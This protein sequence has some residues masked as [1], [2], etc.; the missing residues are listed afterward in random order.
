MRYPEFIK[1]GDTIGF[2]APSFG[3]ASEPYRSAFESSIGA[4]ESMGFNT[5]LGPNC[6]EGSGIGISS[7]PESCGAELTAMYCGDLGECSAIMACGGGELMCETLEHVDLE[8]IAAARPKWYSGFSDNTNFIFPLVTMCDTAAVY[9]PNAP[10][11]GMEPWHKNLS[12]MMDILTGKKLTV[13]SYRRWESHSLKSEENPLEPYN[14][15]EK[16][17]LILKNTASDGTIDMSGRLLGGCMD[18]LAMLCGTGFDHVGKFQERYARDGIIWFLEACDLNVFSMR[19]V[20]WQ[21][22]QAGWFETAKGFII[23]R[24]YH[25]DEPMMGLDRI[26]AVMGIAG[27]HNVPV[28]L[29]ADVG[30][31]PPMMPLVAGS[32]AH[33]RAGGNRMRVSM[34]LVD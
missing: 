5:L 31:L 26:E 24:P 10:A 12:Y 7:S 1:K 2:A 34:K 15:T 4:F 3:C 18:V 30:H 14:C 11:F 17:R 19:R 27:R 9:G 28:I 25:F 33:V 21:L 8:R 29:D 13:G 22:E 6:Y 20:M 23:G 32:L 16:N